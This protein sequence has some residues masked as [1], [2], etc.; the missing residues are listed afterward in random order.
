MNQTKGVEYAGQEDA[1]ANF[2]RIADMFKT[3]GLDIEP[4]HV[5]LVYLQKHLD[6][7]WHIAV[8]GKEL[9]ES[10]RGRILDARL[11][12]ALLYAVIEEKR[13]ESQ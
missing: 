12:L 5:C 3:R 13:S 8:G 2:K 6:A 9:S 10:L 4:E 1:L 7:I 11:Y